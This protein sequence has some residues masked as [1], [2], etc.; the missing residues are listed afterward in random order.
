M[1]KTK[2]KT[3]PIA[4]CLM[5]PTAVGKSALA[6][7]LAEQIPIEI[8]SVDSAMVYRGMDIGTGKPTI[9]ER[10]AVPHHLIDIRDPSEPY[11]AAEFAKDALRIMEEC[12]ARKRVPVL[13]G[14]TMLYFRALLEG[15][16]ILP[17]ADPHIRERLLQEANQI[18]WAA[19]HQRL[20]EIDPLTAKRLHPNDP[21]RI[22]RALEVYEITGKPMSALTRGFAP[23]SP[24]SGRGRTN[25]HEALAVTS[26]LPLAG[27]GAPQGRVRVF[28][29]LPPD[30]KKLHQ[31]IEERFMRMLEQGLVAEAE[32]LYKRGDL[33]LNMPSMRAVGYRQVWGYLTGEYGYEEMV[34]KAIA[35]TRQLAKRQLTWLRS[36]SYIEVL[37]NN[38]L[39][40][41]NT[42]IHCLT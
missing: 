12:R 30:R 38:H 26:P 1:N 37:P 25:E 5:G 31:K 10:A 4:L 27:E 39:A 41:L 19:M 24:A 9:A 32:R 7:A 14:G 40:S 33:N 15:L 18:G 28:A 13:V 17:A 3:T 11:S 42:M 36:L 35:A 20:A 16:S 29:M 6:L 22:Q 34:E 8:I 23:P 2:D 21:Q